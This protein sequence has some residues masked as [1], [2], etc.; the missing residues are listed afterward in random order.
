MID[1]LLRTVIEEIADMMKITGTLEEKCMQI[2]AV[3]H[4]VAGVM[5]DINKT[6]DDLQR[7]QLEK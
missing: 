5:P 3:F 1:Q 4:M 6:V 2:R 7:R